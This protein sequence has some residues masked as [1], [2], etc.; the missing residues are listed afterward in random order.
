MGNVPWDNKRE[1]K[2][3]RNTRELG[4]EGWTQGRNNQCMVDWC[5]KGHQKEY[6]VKRT[7][8]AN[9]ATIR[10]HQKKRDRTSIGKNNIYP[11]RS[12]FGKVENLTS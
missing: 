12:G 5:E 7:A 11:Y 6:R 1:R 8:T 4:P 10:L 3:E 2:G 9:G